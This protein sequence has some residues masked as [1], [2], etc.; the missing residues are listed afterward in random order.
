MK[1]VATLEHSADNCWGRDEHKETAREWIGSTEKRAAEHDVELHGS[2]VTPNEHR[3]Y[4]VLEAERFD[5]VTNFLG[6]PFLEDHDG[7]IAPVMT[8]GEVEESVLE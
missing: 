1:F 5:D 7:R 4:F 6:S 8:F 2:Y 3:M